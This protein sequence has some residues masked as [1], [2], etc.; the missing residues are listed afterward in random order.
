MTTVIGCL[1]AEAFEKFHETQKF[2]EKILERVAL[3]AFFFFLRAA[4][5][6][7]SFSQKIPG[8]SWNFPW[9]R[10]FTRPRKMIDTD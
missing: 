9:G 5:L 4:L 7:I 2:L 6:E 8:T 3:K 10:A 1:H